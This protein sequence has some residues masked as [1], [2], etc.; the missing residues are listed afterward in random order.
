MND[1]AS[2]DNAYHDIPRSTV[3]ALSLT[4]ARF[5]LC[6]IASSSQPFLPHTSWASYLGPDENLLKQGLERVPH[7]RNLIVHTTARYHDTHVGVLSVIIM[8]LISTEGSLRYWLM[9]CPGNH[10]YPGQP[11]SALALLFLS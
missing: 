5:D 9:V 4:L 10:Y 8:A 2:S 3:Q 11:L 6:F 1:E 7:T